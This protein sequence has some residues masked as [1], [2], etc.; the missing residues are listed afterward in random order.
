[1]LLNDFAGRRG[2]NG[3]ILGPRGDFW[4][5]RKSHRFFDRFFMTKVTKK[6]SIWAPFWLQNE[7]QNRCPK[8]IEKKEALYAECAS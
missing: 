4:L 1:M 2:P 3:T 7:V 8:S 6:G 5:A